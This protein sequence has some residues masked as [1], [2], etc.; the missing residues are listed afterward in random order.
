MGEHSPVDALVPSVVCE[1]AV[2]QGVDAGVMLE[3]VEVEGVGVEGWER[4]EW[5]V[6][7]RIERECRRAEQDARA[8]IADSDD[9]GHWFTEYGADWIK[10][11]G[12]SSCYFSF[13]SLSSA[14][15]Q[16]I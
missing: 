10:D 3:G 15:D 13:P 8:L 5:V 14:N 6:D 11:V 9:S 4:L 12:T 7:E 16:L 1:Y 2:V